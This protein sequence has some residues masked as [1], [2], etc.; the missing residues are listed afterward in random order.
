[1]KDVERN[2][3]WYAPWRR[4]ERRPDA[5]DPADLGTAF[6]LDLS[7]AAVEDL[8]PVR[9]RSDPERRAEHTARPR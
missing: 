9:D 3:L 1:M 7:L 2:R 8:A 4:V 5:A 6:G